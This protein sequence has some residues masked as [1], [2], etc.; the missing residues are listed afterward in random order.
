MKLRNE[1][2]RC[3]GCGQASEPFA[4]WTPF[5]MPPSRNKFTNTPDGHFPGIT[6]ANDPKKAPLTMHVCPACEPKVK[7]A[8]KTG[9]FL[10][11]CPDG[12]LKKVLRSILTI[13]MLSNLRPQ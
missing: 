11:H 6:R 8:I 13:K 4:K 1:M 2:L 9:D 5:S 10:K 12:P 7:K 3:D